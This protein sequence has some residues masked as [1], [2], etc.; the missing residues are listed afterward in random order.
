MSYKRVDEVL[1][2]ELLKEIHKYIN[3]E[4]LYIPIKH[5]RKLAWGIKSGYRYELDKRDKTIFALYQKG[6][7]VSELS[8]KY[9]L[10]E[11]SIYRI[12]SKINFII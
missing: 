1:P 6:V 5:E 11:K 12:I 2:T 10:S 9:I 7:T 4:C 3:G 8:E